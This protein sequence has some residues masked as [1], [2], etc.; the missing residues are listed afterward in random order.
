VQGMVKHLL[1]L[2]SD[3]CFMST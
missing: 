2:F 1:L 3:F